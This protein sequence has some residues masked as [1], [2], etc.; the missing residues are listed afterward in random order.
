METQKRI[1]CSEHDFLKAI[2]S[3]E[4]YQE[5]SLKTGQKLSTT[6][7]RYAR[8]KK[9]FFDSEKQMPV[10][11]NKRVSNT[12]E[13]EGVRRTLNKLKDCIE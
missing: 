10:L 4:T 12:K 3:S 9:K 6:I 13:L 5:V 7:S 1:R 2:S 8:L 11:K